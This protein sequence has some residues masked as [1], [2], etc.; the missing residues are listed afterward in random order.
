MVYLH[1]QF[2]VQG[3][4]AGYGNVGLTHGLFTLPVSR[5]RVISGL[6]K[7]RVNPWSIYITSFSCK[8]YQWV[9]ET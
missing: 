8:G 4:S 6:R 5:A 3:L 2:L 1:Y 9:T 7:P